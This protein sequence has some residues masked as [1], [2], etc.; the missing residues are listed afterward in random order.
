[1]RQAYSVISIDSTG[2]GTRAELVDQNTI[3]ESSEVSDRYL[4]FYWTSKRIAAVREIER[5]NQAPD[6]AERWKIRPIVALEILAMFWAWFNTHQSGNHTITFS[7]FGRYRPW[8]MKYLTCCSNRLTGYPSHSGHDDHWRWTAG[9]AASLGTLIWIVASN[10]SSTAPF[11]C[12]QASEMKA[13]ILGISGY[14]SET[15]CL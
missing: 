10:A 13:K 8:P 5:G 14:I 2:C 15:F 9:Y 12:R 11:L 7:A 4:P 6:Q 1:M 3:I